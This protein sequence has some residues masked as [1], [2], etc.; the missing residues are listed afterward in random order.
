L[1]SVYQSKIIAENVRQLDRLST[2]KDILTNSLGKRVI[3]QKFW[4]YHG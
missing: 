3:K 2:N 1:S 4:P